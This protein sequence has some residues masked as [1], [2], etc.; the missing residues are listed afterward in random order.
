MNDE[1]DIFLRDRV[2]GETTR[3]SIADDGTEGNISSDVPSVAADGRYVAFAS[4][5]NNLVP[6]DTNNSLDVFVRDRGFGVV[7]SDG[8]GQMGVPGTT[9]RYALALTNTGTLSDTYDLVLSGGAW[10]ATIDGPSTVTLAASASSEISVVVSVPTGAADGDMDTV[11]LTATSQGNSLVT[12]A[13]DLT[14][15]AS[16]HG[17]SLSGNTAL[18][19][20]PGTTVTYTL[21]LRNTGILTDTYNLALDGNA[22]PTFIDGASSVTLVAG[23]SSAVSVVV[24]I[25]EAAAIGDSDAVRLTAT[26]QTTPFVSD[27]AKLTTTSAYLK[28]YLPMIATP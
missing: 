26:S 18:L 10:P 15:T 11:T 2:T 21:S 28:T 5:A 24:S 6:G 23:A 14:T 27:S 16:H 8:A 25:P 17:V 1:R 7:L 19:A 4:W 22:W 9:V 13:A 3:V 12:S 20:P